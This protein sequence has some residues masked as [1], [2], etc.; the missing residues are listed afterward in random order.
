M[1]GKTQICIPPVD[2]PVHLGINLQYIPT[3]SYLQGIYKMDMYE[4]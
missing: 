2:D 3:P 1:D 4:N